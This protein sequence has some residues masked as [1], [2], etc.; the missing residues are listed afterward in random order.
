[1]NS[2]D[3]ERQTVEI[4]AEWFFERQYY[5]AAPSNTTQYRRISYTL[6]GDNDLETRLRSLLFSY[7]ISVCY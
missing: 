4:V 7:E 1:M 5:G 3:K 6:S 2:P